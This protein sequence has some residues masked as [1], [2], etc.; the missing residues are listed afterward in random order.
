MLRVDYPIRPL[1]EK[2]VELVPAS[3]RHARNRTGD[4]VEIEMKG[5]AGEMAAFEL[6]K[7]YVSLLTNNDGRPD[8]GADFEER[9]TGLRY[10]VKTTPIPKQLWIETYQYRDWGETLEGYVLAGYTP[11]QLAKAEPYWDWDWT[12]VFDDCS[13]Y[14]RGWIYSRDVPLFPIE[15]RERIRNGEQGVFEKY[16]IHYRKLLP[17][18]TLENLFSLSLA[19]KPAT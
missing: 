14:L 4:P 1:A 18:D 17:M 16:I 11:K 3:R 12:C 15:R 6:M 19:S 7:D 8:P 5:I 9:I 2:R 13:A 10:D